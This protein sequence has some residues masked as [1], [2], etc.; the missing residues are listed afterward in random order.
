MRI[1]TAIM[2]CLL[3]L[4]ASGQRVEVSGYAGY[5]S[6]QGDVNESPIFSLQAAH[7]AFGFKLAYMINQ[8]MSIAYNMLNGSISGDDQNFPS[9]KDWVPNLSFK[10]IFSEHSLQ[11]TYYPFNRSRGILSS[12]KVKEKLYRVG[13]PSVKVR[14]KKKFSPFAFAGVGVGLFSPHV[15][16]L[17]TD[18]GELQ[19]GRYKNSHL[20][21]PFGGGVRIEL[22]PRLGISAEAGMRYTL[23]DYLDGI[24]DSRNPDFNDWVVSGGLRV[25][26]KFHGIF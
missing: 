5:A 14:Y 15:S 11:F 2:I 13:C 4:L 12:Y 25:A 22:T 9:R 19:P 3:P 6:Y 20:V 17:P 8:N 1:V 10:S 23:T 24:S 26:Y 18:S 7:P 16:G 21:F